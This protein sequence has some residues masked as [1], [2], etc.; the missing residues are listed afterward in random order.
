MGLPVSEVCLIAHGFVN[1]RHTTIVMLPLLQQH[2]PWYSMMLL[3]D[4]VEPVLIQQ[5]PEHFVCNRFV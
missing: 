5:Y 1:T 4:V 3:N 2:A